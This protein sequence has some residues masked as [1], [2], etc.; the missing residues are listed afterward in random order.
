MHSRRAVLYMPGDD[1]HKIE[2]AASLG[3]DSVCMDLEDGVAIS[4]KEEARQTVVKALKTLDFGNTERLARINPVG[5]GMEGADLDIVIPGTPDG[6]VIPKVASAKDIQWVS[7]KLGKLEKKLG[8]KHGSI[9]LLAIIESAMGIVNLTEISQADGRLKA[10][11][12]GALDLAGDIGAKRTTGAQEVFYARSAVVTHA[13]A[14]GLDAIDM[15]AVDFQDI[16]ALVEESKQGAHLGY[17]GRQIIHPAQV[18]P[19]QTAFTPTEDEIAE[20][21]KLVEAHDAHQQEGKG[22][23]AIDGKMVDMPVVRAA[24]RVLSRSKRI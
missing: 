18:E 17:V 3:V 8:L 1:W 21:R 14:F 11:I 15:V 22:V 7:A 16:A 2:K 24:E 12:F 5:S 6:I 19:V 10:L 13:A 23:F 4:R 9:Y 20:A